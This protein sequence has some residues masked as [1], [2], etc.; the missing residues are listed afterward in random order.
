MSNVAGILLK[1]LDKEMI[2]VQFE[3]MIKARVNSF[4]TARALSGITDDR[5]F[6]LF[7]ND[8]IL[9]SH[10]SDLNTSEGTI[11]DECSVGGANDMGIDGLAIKVNGIFVSTKQD[12]DELIELN[13]QISIEFLFIQTKNKDKLDSGEYGKFTDGIIDFLAD[14]HHEPHNDKIDALLQLKNYLFSDG[15]ILHWK[16][17]PIVRV[18]YVIFGQWHDNKH[19]ESKSEKL[20]QDIENL[21]CYEASHIKFI[22]SAELRRICGEN[23][24]AF[25]TVLTVV[26]NFGLAEVN[27][28]D[29]S[30]IV[31]LSAQELLKMITTDEQIIRQSLFTDNVRAYQGNTDINQEIMNTI[32]NAP[33]IFSLL[34]NGITIVCTSVL[35]S[36]RKITLSNPQI[37]NGCQTCNVLFDAYVQGINCDKVTLLA[38]II[39]T[40]KDTVTSL[41][42]RGTNNQNVVYGEAFETARDFHKNLEEFIYYVQ[43]DAL[44]EKIYYERRSRQYARNSRILNTHIIGLKAL[45][46]SFVSIFMQAPHLGSSHEIIIL[47]KFKN[48]IYIDGQS[49]YPYYTSAMMCLNFEKARREGRINQIAESYRYHIMMIACELIAGISVSINSNR[50]IDEYCIKL[51]KVVADTDE[52]TKYITKALSIVQDAIA[53][54]IKKRGSKYRHGIKD[55]PN[56]T[57]FLL[58]F[59]RGGDTDKIEYDSTPAMILR[60]RVVK[61]RCDRNGYNYGFIQRT[62]DDVFFHELD[63]KTLDFTNVYGKSVLYRVFSDPIK[64]EDRAKIIEVLPDD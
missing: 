13:K 42:I 20:K 17:N 26:D 46:Q 52:Y 12:V 60:G 58:T 6:E 23:E 31:L 57:S 55:N 25:S 47:K 15:V 54:W 51:I 1:L 27:D 2:I 62:P 63:N 33:S 61:S 53:L 36:N 22:D 16:S 21:H 7:V 18:Y 4:R 10:Q 39:A 59:K 28:V 35:V 3:P 40:E 43:R 14:E 56:F 45:T 49:F 8:A 5:L 30:L 41:I 64:G 48:S 24:N 38:K 34:N 11:L 19:I 44:T 32:K 9:C 50:R 37:V 29:N